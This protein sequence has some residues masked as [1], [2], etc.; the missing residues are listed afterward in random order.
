LASHGNLSV[1]MKD[2]VQQIAGSSVAIDTVA[3]FT[4]DVPLPAMVA[5][6]LDDIPPGQEVL[7]FTDLLGGSVNQAFLPYAHRPGLFIVSG[8]FL[9]LVLELILLPAPL[10]RDAID[11]AI[12]RAKSGVIGV[13]N[14]NG[15][16]AK[17]DE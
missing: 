2:T 4:D 14:V 12:D 17:D 8:M 11:G 5:N 10:T 3:A 1:G 6:V 15:E 16:A 13:W 7:V 9:G